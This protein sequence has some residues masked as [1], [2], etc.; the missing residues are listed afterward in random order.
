M[1]NSGLWQELCEGADQ[2]RPFV[3]AMFFMGCLP[4]SLTWMAIHWVKGFMPKRHS[5]A[6]AHTNNSDCLTFA[7]NQKTDSGE[8][9]NFY[10]SKAFALVLLTFLLWEFP[11]SLACRCTTASVL[12]D[13]LSKRHLMIFQRLRE[14]LEQLEVGSTTILLRSSNLSRLASGSRK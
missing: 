14:V 3:L 7:Q 12:V 13:W 4:F 5:P 1:R 2:C 8:P 9:T 6:N 10:S 11:R